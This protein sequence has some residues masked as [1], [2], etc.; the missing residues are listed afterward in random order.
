[1]QSHPFVLRYPASPA[2]KSILDIAHRLIT[3]RAASPGTESFLRRFAQTLGLGGS[4][5]S[6]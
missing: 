3:Q 1:M 5:Q 4:V 2:A 6:A